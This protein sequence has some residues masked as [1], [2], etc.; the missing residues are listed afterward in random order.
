MECDFKFVNGMLPKNKFQLTH[1]RG[2]RH[3]KYLCIALT[4]QDFNSRTHVECDC[5]PRHGANAKMNFNSRTHVECDSIT[6]A[7]GMGVSA[8]FN[9]RTHVECD[10]V[11]IIL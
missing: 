7:I 11:P 10:W 9:S 6:T 2:V 5:F 8:D 1:S 3:L 4:P